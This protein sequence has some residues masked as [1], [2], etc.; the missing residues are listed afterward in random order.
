M[1]EETA[2]PFLRRMVDL[3]ISGRK[4]F[5]RRNRSGKTAIQMLAKLGITSFDEAWE[6]VIAL[7]SKEYFRG[8][9]VDR[10][11]PPGSPPRLFIFKIEVNGILTY[12]KLK[13]DTENRGC[14]CLSFHED[15]K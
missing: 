15:E 12:I 6:I 7:S 8:P 3:I 11:D 4:H 1:C 14:V 10:D 2:E 5:V 13:D 9:V